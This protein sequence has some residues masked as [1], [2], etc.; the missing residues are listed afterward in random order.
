MPAERRNSIP[1]SEFARRWS[2]RL[3]L[4]NRAYEVGDAGAFETVLLAMSEAHASAAAQQL[5]DVRKVSDTMYMALARFRDDSRLA[6]LAHREIPDARLRLE[7]VVAM[8]E[9]AANKTLDLIERSAPLANA[10]VRSAN[11]LMAT[12]DER[13]HDD[14]RVFLEQA[15]GNFEAVRA[16]LSEVML[17]QSFQDLAGQILRGVQRLIG[18]VE[19]AVG[20]IAKVTGAQYAAEPPPA[21]LEGPAV[22]GV[23]HSA[24]TAQD[25]V[26]ALIAELGI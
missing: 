25:D 19:T 5:A 3:A 9:E 13:S 20:E 7:H 12:L 26:D 6:A 4:L 24:V 11:E 8:T 14:I 21:A 18:E 2:G 22:P 15:R 23:T 17:A 16:N 10:T 1:G